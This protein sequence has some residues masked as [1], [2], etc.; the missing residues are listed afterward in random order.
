MKAIRKAIDYTSST[1]TQ[2]TRENHMSKSKIKCRNLGQSD[3]ITLTGLEKEGYKGT[4]L[5]Y[6]S[7]AEKTQALKEDNLSSEHY[8]K[9]NQIHYKELFGIKSSNIPS[10]FRVHGDEE[11][12]GLPPILNLKDDDG[13]FIPREFIYLKACDYKYE[14]DQCHGVTFER[15]GKKISGK[16]IAFDR[17]G[18]GMGNKGNLEKYNGKQCLPGNDSCGKIRSKLC[19]TVYDC[20][21]VYKY[22]RKDRNKKKREKQSV[23]C[24]A[25][26]LV[27]GNS[28]TAYNLIEIQRQLSVVECFKNEGKSNATMTLFNPMTQIPFTPTE[29]K[30]F[31]NAFM[32]SIKRYNVKSRESTLKFLAIAKNSTKTLGKIITGAMTILGGLE[33]VASSP[34]SVSTAAFYCAVISAS[35]VLATTSYKVVSMVPLLKK[36]QITTKQY[37]GIVTSNLLKVAYESADLVIEKGGLSQVETVSTKSTKVLGIR[38]PTAILDDWSPVPYTG[39]MITYTPLG[40]V[41]NMFYGYSFKLKDGIAYNKNLYKALGIGPITKTT[42]ENIVAIIKGLK[43][44]EYLS[45]I[46]NFL[47]G[48]TYVEEDSMI[49]KMLMGSKFGKR[50]LSI[51]VATAHIQAKARTELIPKLSS[52]I[53]KGALGTVDWILNPPDDERGLK[54]ITK[55]KLKQILSR[56]GIT[57]DYIK[58]KLKTTLN[59]AKESFLIEQHIM[60]GNAILY[61]IAKNLAKQNYQ[62]DSGKY[63]APHRHVSK[64][65]AKM[66]YKLQKAR[67]VR[68]PMVNELIEDGKNMQSLFNHNAIC[69]N[70]LYK[71]V[72]N[73]IKKKLIPKLRVIKA[74]KTFR[75]RPRTSPRG[76]T[77]EVSGGYNQITNPRT[78]RKVSINGKLGKQILKNYIGYLNINNI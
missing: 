22:G 42:N 69:I 74:I 78:G 13:N 76:V 56:Y 41:E 61:E 28:I 3:K 15:Y 51:S 50:N 53:E 16:S 21:N 63:F 62:S 4:V 52:K 6:L 77:E 36:G 20:C 9:L 26:D 12:D 40:K 54:G 7:G 30:E 18:I 31:Q 71:K 2:M 8:Q 47:F 73:A 17:N 24:K 64:K 29:L 59:N 43:N 49:K 66:I 33:L 23:Y 5:N 37:A 11:N 44:M 10:I 48:N 75:R 14:P 68:R 38:R 70:K 55:R 27:N 46:T 58:N 72:Q 25:C 32:E 34:V 19:G 67:Q 65:I 39:T 1:L 35:M 60:S 45:E 57:R